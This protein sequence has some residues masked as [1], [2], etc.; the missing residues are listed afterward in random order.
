MNREVGEP[1]SPLQGLNLWDTQ[2]GLS[3]L[4]PPSLCVC[5]PSPS[6]CENMEVQLGYVT[7]MR[8]QGKPIIGHLPAALLASLG[9]RLPKEGCKP[10]TELGHWAS[11]APQECQPLATP[12]R[13]M[14][15]RRSASPSN[16]PGFCPADSSAKSESISRTNRVFQAH[17][18]PDPSV[19]RQ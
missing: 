12:G 19:Y 16:T 9:G 5:L 2:E 17:L 11:R 13:G 3:M 18:L 14:I 6:V 1:S 7:R 15:Q 8:S 10:S 4:P